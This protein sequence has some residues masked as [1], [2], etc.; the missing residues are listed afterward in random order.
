MYMYMYACMY[1][2]MYKHTSS[3]VVGGGVAGSDGCG[4][5]LLRYGLVLSFTIICIQTQIHT[6]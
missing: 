5:R 6:L 4:V 1:M 2:Y 3:A